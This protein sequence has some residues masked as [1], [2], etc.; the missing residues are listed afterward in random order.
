MQD[1]ARDRDQQRD[2]IYGSD[3]MSDTERLQYR[4]KLQSLA[5]EQERVQY[6]LEHQREMQQR[7]QQQGRKL[8][9]APSSNAIQQQEQDRQRERIYGSELM[10]DEELAQHRTQMRTA[11]TAEGHER[12]RAEQHAQMQ[13]RAAERG[14]T[15]VEPRR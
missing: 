9:T 14:V 5:T 12:I 2:R 8:G 10:T 6:R 3:L 1:A 4:Q 15:L 11:T 13:K 7:A